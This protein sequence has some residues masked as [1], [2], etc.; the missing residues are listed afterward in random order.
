MKTN[1]GLEFNTKKVHGW[2]QDRHINTRF[3][4]P[5]SPWQNGHDESFNGVFKNGCLNRRSFESAI[6]SRKA[7]EYW[8]YEY[9]VERSHGS[10]SGRSSEIC[11]GQGEQQKREAA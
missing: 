2:I 7:T 10:L 8:L 11:F 4:D 5:G 6:E 3:F 1:N 9:N